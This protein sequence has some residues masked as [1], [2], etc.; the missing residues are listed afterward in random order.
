MLNDQYLGNKASAN[1]N[2]DA[3]NAPLFSFQSSMGSTLWL[4]C[5]SCS[6]CS[7]ELSVRDAFSI[8]SSNRNNSVYASTFDVSVR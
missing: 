6:S 4:I 5:N 8:D 1:K 3:L 7:I 2:L